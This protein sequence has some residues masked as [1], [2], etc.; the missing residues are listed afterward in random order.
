M[1]DVFVTRW[2]ATHLDRRGSA[3]RHLWQT[4]IGTCRTL[5]TSSTTQIQC[6]LGMKPKIVIEPGWCAVQKFKKLC[7]MSQTSVPK[8]G[9]H[10]RMPEA[11]PNTCFC[12]QVTKIGKFWIYKRTGQQ[13]RFAFGVQTIWF[14]GVFCARCGSGACHH[15]ARCSGACHSRLHGMSVAPKQLT[16]L[17]VQVIINPLGDF[18]VRPKPL[19]RRLHFKNPC[20]PRSSLYDCMIDMR[21]S[22]WHAPRKD[23]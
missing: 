9:A 3:I 12:C 23:A 17:G 1:G 21:L 10:L 18:I 7:Q 2:S 11:Q 22:I 6:A 14:H 13:V 16:L 20:V 8:S 5:G 4:S 19:E 15:C